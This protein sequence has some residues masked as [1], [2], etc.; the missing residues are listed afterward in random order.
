MLLFSVGNSELSAKANSEYKLRI[1]GKNSHMVHLGYN[2]L[3]AVKKNEERKGENFCH[4]SKSATVDKPA[5]AQE[6]E[7]IKPIVITIPQVSLAQ[8]TDCLCTHWD[9]HCLTSVTGCAL[10]T[11]VA[12]WHGDKSL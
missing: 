12:C 5:W 11:F 4:C 9:T 6:A 2:C 3:S 10:L 1:M 8:G 7:S